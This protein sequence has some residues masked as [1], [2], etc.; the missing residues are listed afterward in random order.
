MGNNELTNLYIGTVKKIILGTIYDK[1]FIVIKKSNTT[2]IKSY[3]KNSLLNI[4]EKFGIGLIRYRNIS[5]EIIEEGKYWPDFA[6]S[7]LGQ[8]RMDNAQYCCETVIK[9][10]VPGDFVECGVWRGGT[11]IFM[12]AILKAYNIK[13]RIVWVADSFEGL[14]KPNPQKYPEDIGD[15]HHKIDILKVGIDEVKRNFEIFGLLD[16]EVKFLKGWFKD[17]LPNSQIEN[18]SVLR[19]DGDIYESTW[20]SLINLYPKLQC[21]GFLIIDDYF[22]NYSCRKAVEDYFKQNNIEVNILRIDWSGAYC[23]KQ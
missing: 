3:V 23:R 15:V 9:E 8:K 14:P 6:Y 17:T 5:K 16:N 11:T 20:D 21:N 18:I 1:N 13:D 4:I 12:R 22:N 7:M 2:K 19:L 10:N